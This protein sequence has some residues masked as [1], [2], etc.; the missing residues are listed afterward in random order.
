MGVSDII[1]DILLITFPI[2]VIV[3]SHITFKRKIQLILLFGM[4]IILIGITAA[5]V[6]LVI[7][8]LGLQQYRSVF[9]SA[10]ILAAAAI[11]NAVILGSFLRDKGVKKTKRYKFGST[12]D[13]MDRAQQSR[14][15]TITTQQWGSDEDLVRDMGYRLHPSLVSES[16]VVARPAPVATPHTAAPKKTDSPFAGKPWQFPNGNP[17]GDNDSDVSDIKVPVAQ[18]PNPS[19]GQ[20]EV[21]PPRRLS[22]FD[23]GGLLEDGSMRSSTLVPSPVSTVS[24]QDFAGPRRGSRALLTDLGGLLGQRNAR[25]SAPEDNPRESMEDRELESLSSAPIHRPQP[26]SPVPE[27]SSSSDLARFLREESPPS[28]NALRVPAHRP[29][30]SSS[31]SPGPAAPNFSRPRSTQRAPQPVPPPADGHADTSR[32]ST[33]QD[34]GGLLG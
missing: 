26:A 33:F 13:S 5:R 22:F 29:S 27:P 18:D 32:H 17:N 15:G 3:K 1:T 21:I 28:P 31:Q 24:A 23:V 16:D 19:P 11:S 2:P 8:R 9:A 25:R 4:S 14:R 10:E 7:I 12:S 6:P 34:V 20:V 30:R